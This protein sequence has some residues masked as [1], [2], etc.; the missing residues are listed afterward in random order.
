MQVVNVRRWSRSGQVRSA[1]CDLAPP[2]RFGDRA[3]E[4]LTLAMALA[5]VALVVLVG[6]QLATRFVRS[7]SRRFGLS[8]LTTSTWD[9]VAEEFGA[10]PFI[11]G[12]VVSSLIALLIAV[13]LSIATAVYLTEL[14]P[15][16]LRQPLISLIEMLAAI[17]SVILGL[18][19]IFVMVP[20]LRAHPF[21]LLEKRLRLA[22]VFQRTDLRREHAGRRHH[23]RHH[24]PADHHLGFAGNSA[25]RAGSA[26][27]SRLRPR[28]DALGSHAHRRPELRRK[29]GCSARSFLGSAA[30]WAKRWRS[31]WS[32]A[33]RRRSTRRF[34]RPA[35]P[36]PA[37]S[38]TNSPKPR[39]IIYLQALFE[40]G[41]V[42]F[43]V[44]ILVNLLAQ[45]LL[46]TMVDVDDHARG[47]M[48]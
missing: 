31:R 21:P 47:A 33:T 25:L 27:R 23:H 1:N 14:A 15:L 38:P 46:K 5:V 13:P 28:R 43:G 10:L 17:P 48:R 42:L 20:W 44:T 35:T 32:S 11:Y 3:F 12:T 39:P 40:I 18:W 41:L 6:W 7:P 9:P 22:A 4:W 8:F 29:A 30:R 36:W 24:D 37:S 16:W 45:L 26:T 2:S 19:G 34:S